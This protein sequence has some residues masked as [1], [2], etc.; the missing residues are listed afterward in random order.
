MDWNFGAKDLESQ[1]E[2]SKA[3]NRP[4]LY[5]VGLTVSSQV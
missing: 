2:M 4:T 5:G 1:V 3:R